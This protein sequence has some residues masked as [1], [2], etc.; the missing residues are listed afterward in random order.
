MSLKRKTAFFYILC[1]AAAALA[2]WGF[3]RVL[4]APDVLEAALSEA[5]ERRLTEA[6][7]L[8]L[9]TRRARSGAGRAKKWEL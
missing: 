4:Q 6:T 1:A 7:A 8:L 3:I 2:L 9:E 5:R